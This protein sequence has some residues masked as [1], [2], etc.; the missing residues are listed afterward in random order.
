MERD[1]LIPSLQL[2]ILL[3][4]MPA[5][6]LVLFLHAQPPICRHNSGEPLIS[7]PQDSTGSRSSTQPINPSLQKRKFFLLI[8]IN[9]HQDDRLIRDERQI[10][11]GAFV[12][13][14]V[15]AVCEDGVQD[16]G[17]SFD[18]GDVAGD[19]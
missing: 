19:G 9:D 18:L 17:D 5:A 6:L 11:I 8:I 13:N 12:A 1:N 7:F 15:F 14:E 16:A 3:F 4:Q 10:G 2:R